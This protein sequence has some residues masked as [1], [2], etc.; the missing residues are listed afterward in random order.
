MR[1]VV[2]R[3][4]EASVTVG[5]APVSKIGR[6][7]LVL[8]AVSN[9]D[10][11]GDVVWLADKIVNL[12]IFPDDEAAMNRSVVEAG[13]EVLAV[14]QFTLYGDARRGRRPSFIEAAPR[15]TAEPL[16]ELLCERIRGLGVP[17][18]AGVF[19]A[20]MQVGL[21]NDGPVTILLD[22]ARAF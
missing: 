20:D 4:S 10:G 6:G 9:A 21:V 1:A 16:I 15:A 18:V 7:L 11:E 17:V 5:G 22:S 13:G 14:S 3:V 8:A 19:G 12:R 2:Q